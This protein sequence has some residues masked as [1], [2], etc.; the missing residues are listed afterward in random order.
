MDFLSPINDSDETL[1][2]FLSRDF[3]RW[4]SFKNETWKLSPYS[5]PINRVDFMRQ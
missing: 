4:K 2:K 5:F 1:G 3:S